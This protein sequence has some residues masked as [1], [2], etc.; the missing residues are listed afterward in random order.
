MRA[1]PR[2]PTFITLLLLLAAQ[3]VLAQQVVRDYNFKNEQLKDAAGK[4]PDLKK[5][6]G[7]IGDG[8]FTFAAGD[9]LELDKAGVTDHYTLEVTVEFEETSSW[10]KIFD[11]KSQ[12]SDNGLYVYNGQLQ[13]YPEEPGGE[14]Q[15]NTSYRIRLECDKATKKV[16]GFIN[17]IRSFEFI[18]GNDMAVIDNETL[19]LFLDD[20]TTSSEISAG[21][22][23]RLR[24]WDAPGGE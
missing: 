13:F 16:Q 6:M 5:Q 11:F 2:F 8:K 17:G 14:I 15:A 20:V 23:T 7:V 22:T 10:R 24:I 3:A 12:N 18:D 19:I 4:G 21:V 9:G 1:S